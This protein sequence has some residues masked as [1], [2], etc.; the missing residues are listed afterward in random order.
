MFTIEN[1]IFSLS[2]KVVSTSYFSLLVFLLFLG[3]GLLLDVVI[4]VFWGVMCLWPSAVVA[5]LAE[6]RQ[7]QGGNLI[8]LLL[9]MSFVSKLLAVIYAY[10]IV[11]LDLHDPFY[12]NSLASIIY[13]ISN[14]GAYAI[15]ILKLLELLNNLEARSNIKSPP[16]L[17]TMGAILIPGLGVFLLK[18]R[19][20]K[21]AA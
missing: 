14:I 5:R 10:L 8:R 16:F 20:E 1:T 17:M 6:V 12:T 13:L 2:P 4:V 7:F 19:I 15:G 18:K 3:K 21:L 9:L 11:E